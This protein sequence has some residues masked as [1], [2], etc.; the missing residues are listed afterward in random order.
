M[1]NK[2]YILTSQF[3]KAAQEKTLTLYHGT[4]LENAQKLIENGWQPNK[5]SSG[6]N[7]G[8]PKYLYL[9]TG[10][11][12][13]MWFA[14]EKG[15]DTVVILNNVP[16]EYLIPDPEDAIGD[17]AEHE[18]EMANK[19]NFPAKFALTVS[20]PAEYFEITNKM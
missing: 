2:L 3:Y 15:C 14:N 12:D 9:T 10:Y 1:I 17:T 16:L 11:D 6:G 4:C 8:N 7:Q 5:V 19:L 13:A 18:L 20:L